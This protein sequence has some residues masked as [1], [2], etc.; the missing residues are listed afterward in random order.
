MDG[1]GGVVD[2]RAYN[3]HGGGRQEEGVRGTEKGLSWV[4]ESARGG[5]RYG[6]PEVRSKRGADVGGQQ[7]LLHV[8]DDGLVG[9]GFKTR[10]A[11]V[12]DERVPFVRVYRNS[13]GGV[14]GVGEE[15]GNVRANELRLVDNSERRE[16][17][18]EGKRWRRHRKNVHCCKIVEALHPGAN[19]GGERG[20]AGR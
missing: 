3:E 12:V 15:G 5:K 14:A 4:N 9:A 18:L 2:A 11:E 6:R 17:V 13:D 1:G 8:I 19:G 10:R 16:T 7:L 20:D